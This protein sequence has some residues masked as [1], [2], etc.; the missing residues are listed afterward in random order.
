MRGKA[1]CQEKPPGGF[2][3]LL[4][5][6]EPGFQRTAFS[7]GKLPQSAAGDNFSG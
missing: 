2:K 5:I 4:N 3:V 6:E 1:L 7:G